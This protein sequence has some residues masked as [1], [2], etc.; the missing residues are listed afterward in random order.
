MPDQGAI[1]RTALAVVLAVA[2][3]LACSAPAW[4][5]TPVH[6]Y[7]VIGYATDW[8]PTQTKDL[9][10]ID[11]LIFAFAEVHA[12]RVTLTREAGHRLAKLVALKARD[13][14]L[15]VDISIGGWGAGGFSEAAAT[16][17][18]RQAFADTATQL[19][20]ASH[21]D[22]IDVDW[23]YPGSSQGGIASSPHDRENFTLLLKALRIRLDA[24]GAEGHRHYTLSI[25]VADGPLA[26]G[27]DIA[28]VNR[29]V[30]WFN[31][32][33][34]DFCNSLTPTTCHQAG[35]YA[36]KL[37][38]AGARTGQ[39]AVEQYLAAGVAPA[40]LVLGAAFYGREF[41]EVAP[42]HDGLYQPYKKFI[43]FVPWSKLAADFIDKHG[44]V[45]HWDAQA[46]AAWLW[47]A[48]TRTFISYDDPEALA[49]KAAFVRQ[50]HLGGIMY[51]EQGLD[52]ADTLLDAIWKGLHPASTTAVTSPGA[53]ATPAR[54]WDG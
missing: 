32:M 10:K 6:R 23:E 29:Y 18:G 20:V 16:A 39:R 50:H 47:N 54:N 1:R 49:A 19:V 37:A 17:A 36:S 12:D 14:G 26:D 43:A 7:R 44:F 33:T 35:L 42:A 41:G 25:A 45:R 52:P 3:C 15:K 4:A 8:N 46:S 30:D 28:A 5:A 51:W 48:N 31:L 53:T 11:T 24:A 9:D 40:Q 27:V 2:A 38:P 34:Y 13:P 21:A 22:G